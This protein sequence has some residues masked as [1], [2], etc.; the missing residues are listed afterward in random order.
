MGRV[1]H[2]FDMV[3]LRNVL[4]TDEQLDADRKAIATRTGTDAQLWDAK[5]RE[6]PGQPRMNAYH[7]PEKGRAGVMPPRTL[8]EPSTSLRWRADHV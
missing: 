5:K 7:A 6:L 8:S 2:F 3:D 1:L 4:V